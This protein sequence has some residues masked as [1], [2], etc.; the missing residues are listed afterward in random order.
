MRQLNILKVNVL[1][2]LIKSI[3]EG[4]IESK[5][6]FVRKFVEWMEPTL[7]WN[8][9]SINKKGFTVQADLF[10]TAR[11]SVIV[12]DKEHH[13]CQIIDFAIPYDTRADDKE[14]EKIKN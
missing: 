2:L 13:E 1:N 9:M 11:R 4:L 14:V 10:I 8:G 7:N 12:I 6:V 3:K 5:D